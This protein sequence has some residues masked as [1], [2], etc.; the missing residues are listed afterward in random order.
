M[1][2]NKLARRG[3]VSRVRS[4]GP[5]EVSPALVASAKLFASAA[6]AKRTVKA[7]RAD[8]EAFAEWCEANGLPAL[9]AA[10]ATV[11]LY[12]AARATQGRKVATI[13]REL[14]A[15][16]QAHKAAGLPS[17]RT[18]AAVREVL[19]GI[20]RTLGVAQTR[21]AP[22]LPGLLRDI[23]AALPTGLLGNRDRALLALGFAGGFR[24][25]EL[26]A[27]DVADL[28]FTAEGLEV[29]LRRSKTDQEGAGRKIGI[30]VGT[31][32]EGCPVRALRAWLDAAAIT[33]GPLFRA[34]TRHGRVGGARLNERSIAK[35][36]K[37][38]VKRAGL[39]PTTFSG[40][41]L[42]AGLV[43]AAAKARKTVE[44]IMRQTGH[45]SVAMVHRYIRDAAL[46]DDNAARGLL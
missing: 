23:F 26:A 22:L 28:N 30:P 20:R 37:R 42:R 18:D 2:T 15:I 17:P 35:I 1:E 40:H 43:T 32:P 41:S 46:F 21:K 16:S 39:D 33:E 19:A 34:V 8:W 6:R 10:P 44:S 45:R 31:H 9:P 4:A 11:A 3:G 25:S 5:V 14:A 7:Y 24:R 38:N 36:V 12:L 29:I 13:T 27:L